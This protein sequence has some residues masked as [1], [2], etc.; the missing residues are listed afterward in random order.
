MQRAKIDKFVPDEDCCLELSEK[1]KLSLDDEKDIECVADE[2]DNDRAREKIDEMDE[3]LARFED[4][5]GTSKM[6]SGVFNLIVSR[7][8]TGT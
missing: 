7:G 3:D 8:Y 1:E 2:T 6:L 4:T 5:A